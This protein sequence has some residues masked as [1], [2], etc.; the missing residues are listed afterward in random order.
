MAN[1]LKQTRTFQVAVLRKSDHVTPIQVGDPLDVLLFEGSKRTVTLTVVADG[2]KTLSWDY[3]P[4]AITPTS[5]NGTAG[6]AVPGALTAVINTTANATDLATAEALANAD[7]VQGNAE[8]VDITAIRT[9]EIALATEAEKIGDDV[10]A[11]IASAVGVLAEWVVGVD[12]AHRPAAV[13]AP[14]HSGG[15]YA[16]TPIV[17]NE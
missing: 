6:A 4:A 17:N 8:L 12:G 11:V 1:G 2:G 5:T 7:K 13:S 14:T 15:P 3:I 10:R 16:F 9:A